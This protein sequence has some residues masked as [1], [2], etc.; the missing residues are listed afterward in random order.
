M[1]SLFSLIGG[2]AG[3]CAG[4]YSWYNAFAYV[5][6]LIPASAGGEWSGLIH[7]AILIGFW[8]LCGGLCIGSLM[9]ITMIG[10]GIGA[11]FAVLLGAKD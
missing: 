8:L 6:S 11:F 2:F 3:L 1:K 4:I 7:F 9:L 10:T 5:L